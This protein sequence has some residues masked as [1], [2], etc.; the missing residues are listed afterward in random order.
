MEEKK[1]DCC[2]ERNLGLSP[3]KKEILTS[4]PPF[5]IFNQELGE[6]MERL[7]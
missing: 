2:G 6:N 1:L 3:T 7:L 5:L 4:P